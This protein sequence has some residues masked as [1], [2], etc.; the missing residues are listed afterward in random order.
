M[1]TDKPLAQY[2]KQQGYESAAPELL[3]VF[4]ALEGLAATLHTIPAEVQQEKADY[5]ALIGHLEQAAKA[6]QRIEGRLPPARGLNTGTAEQQWRQDLAAVLEAVKAKAPQ[7]KG[8]R[9]RN[10]GEEKQ[11]LAVMGALLRHGVPEQRILTV[12]AECLN[13]LGMAEES[14]E[15][16]T[17]AAR[18]LTKP[19]LK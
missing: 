13:L 8:G 16:A 1:N 5:L 10:I 6:A 4:K 14:I 17:R 15:R 2:L 9:P 19:T 7:P 12:T 3:R 18:S 11:A